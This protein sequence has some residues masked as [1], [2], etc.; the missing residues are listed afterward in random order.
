MSSGD[1]QTTPDGLMICPVPENGMA[2][3]MSHALSQTET[4]HQDYLAEVA[5]RMILEFT[6]SDSVRLFSELIKTHFG[7][8]PSLMPRLQIK[9]LVFE[10]AA[11]AE[12]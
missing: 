4:V 7:M 5:K 1:L 6:T 10:N 2:P 8:D 3:F 12:G 9:A 11:F